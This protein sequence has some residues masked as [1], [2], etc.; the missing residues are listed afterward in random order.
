MAGQD[1]LN[2]A[3]RKF[4]PAAGAAYIRFPGEPE[5]EEASEGLVLGL[6]ERGKIVGM[7]SLEASKHVAPEIRRKLSERT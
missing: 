7:E 3:H 5:N 4:D 2:D 1:G 6:D